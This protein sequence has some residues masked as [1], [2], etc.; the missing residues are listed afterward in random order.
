MLKK[1]TAKPVLHTEYTDETGRKWVQTSPDDLFAI[2]ELSDVLEAIEKDKDSGDIVLARID[3][4]KVNKEYY[5]AV[6][7]LQEKLRRKEALLQKLTTETRRV[8]DRKNKKLNE[9]IA[10]IRKL[11]LR[12]PITI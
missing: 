2:R 12:W 7:E 8:L 5:D 6:I 11:H 1:K 3:F 9:L 10:Y 4:Q